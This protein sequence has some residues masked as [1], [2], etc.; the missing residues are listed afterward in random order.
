MVQ[1]VYK[2]E[3]FSFEDAMTFF[4]ECLN[5]GLEGIILKSKDGKWKDGKPNYQVK[6]KLEMDVDLEIVG[7]NYG[8]KGTK[9]EKV[10]SSLICKSLD[11]I[12]TAEPGG[13]DEKTMQE[14]TNSQEELLGKIVH[15]KC[16]GITQANGKYS[17]LHPRVGDQKFRD[18][19]VVADTFQQIKDN[20]DMCKGLK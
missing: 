11:G 9:N 3:L 14:V 19:K 2:K 12:L 6:L 1:P 10:I 20:E 16:C 18:D 13:M 8:T 4:Q 5:K 15:V 17:L 7:F